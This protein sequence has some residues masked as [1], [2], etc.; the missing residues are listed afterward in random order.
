MDQDTRNTTP[1]N[2]P[3]SHD[4]A[5]KD[6]LMGNARETKGRVEE[7]LGS[8]SGDEQLKEKGTGDQAS[9]SIR[10]TKGKIKERVKSW[11]DHR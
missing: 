7:G 2:A 8:L 3:T 4:S 6:R 1:E 11:V 9:G 10:K 5:E